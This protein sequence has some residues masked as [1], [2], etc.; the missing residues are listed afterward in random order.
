[1]LSEEAPD[2]GARAGERRVWIVDPLDGTREFRAGR[3]EWAVHVGLAIDG[4]AAVGAVAL[5]AFGRVLDSASVPPAP[6]S[7]DT[8][9]I[10]VSRSRA[11]E[12]CAGV[13]ERLGATL[14]PM[15]SAGGQDHGGRRRP[16]RRVS[17]QRWPV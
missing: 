10:V 8:L 14:I 9:R 11:P 17:A 2:D 7:G 5:P 4:E 6:A 15:G 3:D 16:G 12:L 13:A 1:M